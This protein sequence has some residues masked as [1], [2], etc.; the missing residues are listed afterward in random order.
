M[1]LLDEDDWIAA[2]L[3][4]PLETED[5]YRKALGKLRWSAK[6]HFGEMMRQAL[7]KYRKAMPGQMPAEMAQLIPYFDSPP[8]DD[9]LQRYEIMALPG[10]SGGPAIRDRLASIVDDKYDYM[11]RVGAD[12]GLGPS[13]TTNSIAFMYATDDADQAFR[14][15]HNG[16]KP[17]DPTDIV[18]YFSHAADGKKYSEMIESYRQKTK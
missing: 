6:Q 4:Q 17:A 2:L 14:A 5:D 10:R 11:I 12:G 8:A 9:M 13:S 16:A 1:R 7:N 3:H 15:A 18:P